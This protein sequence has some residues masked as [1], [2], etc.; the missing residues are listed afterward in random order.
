LLPVVT[1]NPQ[2]YKQST[3][4]AEEPRNVVT[5][6]DLPKRRGR[7]RKSNLLVFSKV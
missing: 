1:F 6:N 5:N 4:A 7:A 3:V 2:S